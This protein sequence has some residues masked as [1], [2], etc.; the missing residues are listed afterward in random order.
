[1]SE[2]GLPVSLEALPT[3]TEAGVREQDFCG[4]EAGIPVPEPGKENENDL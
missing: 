4:R 1:M 2:G 3:L